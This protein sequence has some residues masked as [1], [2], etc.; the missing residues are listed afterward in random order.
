[1]TREYR[2]FAKSDSANAEIIKVRDGFITGEWIYG[3]LLKNDVEGKTYIVTVSANGGYCMNEVIAE[4]VGQ[5]G[6]QNGNDT[7]CGDGK[8]RGA[9]Q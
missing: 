1:M 4:T 7:A 8:K 6:R 5:A 9:G 3:Y 2:G